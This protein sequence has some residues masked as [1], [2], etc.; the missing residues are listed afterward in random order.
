M[1]QFHMDAIIEIF[2]TP[3]LQEGQVC[4]YQESINK[5]P[6]EAVISEKILLEGRRVDIGQIIATK[7]K[8]VAEN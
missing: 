4:R 3:R 5:M 2:G 7:M 1:I 8:N 6:N